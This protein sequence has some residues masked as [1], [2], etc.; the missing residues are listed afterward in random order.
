MVSKPLPGFTNRRVLTIDDSAI[1]RLFLRRLLTLRGALVEEAACGQDALVLFAAGQQ[2]DLILLDL[3]LPDM[4][5][6]ELLQHLRE[7]DEHTTVIL[8]TGQGDVK[9]ATL[10]VRQGADG[11]IA[12]QHI[13][14]GEDGD[15]AEFFYA[16]E[17]AL[18]HRAALVA[19]NQLEEIKAD[20]YSMLTHELRNPASTILFATQ[21]LLEEEEG[22]LVP[23]QRELIEMIHQLTNKF[24]T[25]IN[26]YLDFTKLD[27]GQFHIDLYE[28]ELR[29]LVELSAKSGRQQ[30]RAKGQHFTLEIPP[31]PVL[32]LVDAERL[33]QVLD[34]LVGNAIKYTPAE[35]E[36]IVRL[37]QDYQTTILSVQDTGVGIPPKEMEV[38]FTKYHRV[39]GAPKRGIQGTGLGLLIVKEIVEAHG[40]SIQAE[41]AGIP[42]KGTTFTI[43]LPLHPLKD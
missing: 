12:K 40:G 21:M 13:S 35:G 10:A 30:A 9:S 28:V 15:Y 11:Y 6:F 14:I 39:P 43:R 41:S 22:T 23:R 7:K 34:N 1:I 32:A 16:I 38:L 24:Y 2:F 26:N 8:L 5:G 27:A 4:D 25:L 37:Q 18:A 17:Q 20:F 19:Y 36:I 3:L 29:D 42:G 31:E 33:T